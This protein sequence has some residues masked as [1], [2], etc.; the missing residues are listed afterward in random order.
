MSDNGSQF[1][2]NELNAFFTKMGINH[3][4]TALYSPQSNASE[5]VNR[6]LIAGIRA[7]LK[8]DQTLWDE[9]LSSISCSLRNSIHTTIHTSP[10]HAVFGLDMITHGSSYKLLRNVNLLNENLNPLNKDDTLALLRQNITEK[11]SEAYNTNKCQYNLR[12]RPISYSVGQFVF[13]RNF[14]QSNLEKKFN[15]KLAPLYIKAKIREKIGRNYYVLEDLN[16][17]TIGT[18]HAKDLK[19]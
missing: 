7:Y 11:M 12:A 10:Y 5:R 13:R 16:G 4:Y 9:N 1:K 8:K 3:I 19:S 17:K 15:S 14:V 18:F 2:A 6:S